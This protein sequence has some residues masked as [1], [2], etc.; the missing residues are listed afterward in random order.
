MLHKM[1]ALCAI[2]HHDSREAALYDW[3]VLGIYY[4]FRLGEWAQNASTKSMLL[5]SIDGSPIAFTFNDITFYGPNRK[6]LH[7]SWDTILDPT[8]VAE[9]QLRWTVQKNSTTEKPSPKQKTQTLDYAQ[10]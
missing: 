3:N 9:V 6:R 10:C 7:Q 1:H 8:A 4:G 5:R 2:M